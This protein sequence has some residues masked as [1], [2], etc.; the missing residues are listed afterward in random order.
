[1]ST[2]R[3]CKHFN[4]QDGAPIGQLVGTCTRYPPVPL[5]LIGQHQMTQQ[6]VQQITAQFPV[7]EQG[8]HCGEHLLRAPI[9]LTGASNG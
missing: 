4:A 5:V 1:M 7:V 6:M 2:C 8:S 3:T 9:Q